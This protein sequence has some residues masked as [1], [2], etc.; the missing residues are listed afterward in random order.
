MD[1]EWK[2]QGPI[3]MTAA[4]HEL[5]AYNYKACMCFAL[6]AAVCQLW[7]IREALEKHD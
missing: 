5:R 3:Y 4:G 2:T 6:L 7:G 1:F